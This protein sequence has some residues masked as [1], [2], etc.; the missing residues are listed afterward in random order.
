M[1]PSVVPLNIS[2]YGTVPYLIHSHEANS[3]D[4]GFAFFRA[5]SPSKQAELTV[6]FAITLTLCC[7]GALGNMLVLFVTCPKRGP[8]TKS[9]V[10]LL[11]FHFTSLSFAMCLVNIPVTIFMIL[12]KRDGHGVVDDTV[13]CGIIHTVFIING[14]LVNWS[15]LTLC[16]NR[17]VALFYPYKYRAL[18]TRKFNYLLIASCWV[19]TLAIALPMGTGV[20]GSMV[21]VPMGNCLLRSKGEREATIFASL[22]SY[23]PYGLNGMGSLAI[24]WKSHQLGRSRA[25]GPLMAA[26]R[27]TPVGR[28]VRM[29]Q[30]VMLVWVWSAVCSGPGIL[31]VSKFPRLF[32][33]NPVS[34]LWLRTLLT[35]QYGLVPVGEVIFGKSRYGTLNCSILILCFLLVVYLVPF[36]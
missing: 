24:I 10:S 22:V 21:L 11:I 33:T 31:I 17:C 12:A 27:L 18:S 2:D 28:R 34:V 26:S 1:A 35:L 14:A 19:V 9:G 30:M 25:V 16:A 3:S 4:S 32:A 36:Q 6:W 5:L 7:L 15:D 29:A 8:V 23:V 20:T 13:S